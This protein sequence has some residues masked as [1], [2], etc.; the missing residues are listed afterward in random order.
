MT[1]G[2]VLVA[3]LAARITTLL[4]ADDDI[5][6]LLHE[7]VHERGHP[8]Q[9]ALPIAAFDQDVFALHVTEIAQ[10]LL[11]CVERGISRSD[12]GEYK[13]YAGRGVCRLLSLG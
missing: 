11:E 8:I 7:L 13:A 12:R 5:D 9:S 1:I 10:S 4:T 3:S 2:I 6:F